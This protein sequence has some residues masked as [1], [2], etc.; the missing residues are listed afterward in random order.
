MARTQK[1][2]VKFCK[3]QTHMIPMTK[4]DRAALIQR[5]LTATRIPL[6]T[7]AWTKAN[8]FSDLVVETYPLAQVIHDLTTQFINHL[9]A[10]ASAKPIGPV[11]RTPLSTLFVFVEDG[12]DEAEYAQLLSSYRHYLHRY[13][14]AFVEQSQHKPGGTL[15]RYLLEESLDLPNSHYFNDAIGP[16]TVA[17]LE[18]SSYFR[19]NVSVEQTT[20]H[21]VLSLRM[22]DKV[23]SD[24]QTTIHRAFHKDMVDKASVRDVVDFLMANFL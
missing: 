12:T 21:P 1:L 17:N 9:P 18:L 5:G 23:G 20:T 7:F 4:E 6:P 16:S 8:Y 10:G 2:A 13:C 14:F 19:L 3:T 15:Y 11:A 22:Q 24:W